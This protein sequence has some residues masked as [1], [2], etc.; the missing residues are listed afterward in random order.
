MAFIRLLEF[1]VQPLHGNELLPFHDW[2]NRSNVSPESGN[3]TTQ[4]K[5]LPGMWSLRAVDG[6]DAE[7]RDEFAG[8]YAFKRVRTRDVAEVQLLEVQAREIAEDFDG[9]PVER[10]GE[11]DALEGAANRIT[12]RNRE[13]RRGLAEV[14]QRRQFGIRERRLHSCRDLKFLWLVEIVFAAEDRETELQRTIEQVRLGE[15]E[16]DIALAIANRRLHAERFYE[17]EEIVGLVG[18]ADKRTGES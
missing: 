10:V 3:F 5:A 13:A 8:N 12:R 18:E 14:L 6:A 17:S 1:R 2:A 15:A 7:A 16:Q 9:E 4:I 11:S